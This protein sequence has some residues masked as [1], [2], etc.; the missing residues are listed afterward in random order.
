MFIEQNFGPHIE[1]KCASLK[2]SSGSVSSCMA[3]AVFGIER[4]FELL[5]PVERVAGARQSV[6]TI[7]GAGTMTRD[8]GGMRGNL[9]RDQPG[10]H[11]FLVRQSEVFLGRDIAEHR[12]P[13][14]ADQRGP[15][16][17][18]D[19]VV[20]RSDVGDQRAQRVEG[21]LVAQ[22]LLLEHLHLDLVQRN[23]P[24]ALRSSPAT[25]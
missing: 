15:D 22:L 2:P 6:V 17:R 16:G 5:V 25:S 21:R 18:G 12:R 9:I 10:L 7:A 24:P 8:I 1:Q 3:R 11:V 19:V 20:A 23:V 14:P 13:V 4:K